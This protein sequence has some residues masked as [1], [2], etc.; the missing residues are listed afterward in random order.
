MP[1]TCPS[2]RIFLFLLKF[3]AGLDDNYRD[4]IENIPG[5]PAHQGSGQAPPS[6]ALPEIAVD[7]Y[8]LITA[9]Q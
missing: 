3:L 2:L 8:S 5:I 4:R 9:A 1:D 6:R 7:V